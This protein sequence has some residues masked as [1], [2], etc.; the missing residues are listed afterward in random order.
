METEFCVLCGSALD[1]SG[2]CQNPSCRN[3]Q[4]A[5]KS[6]TQTSQESFA[7]S[8]KPL[9]FPEK[10]KKI[11]PDCI[12]ADLDEVH[13]KQYDIARLQTL[14]KGAR[15]EG[16]LQ[17]TN[18]RV[19]FRSTGFSIVGPT[20]LQHEFSIEEIA[21]IEIRKEAKLNVFTTA[22]LILA[23]YIIYSILNP[24]FSA[25][26][27]HAFIG[28]VFTL[29]LTAASVILFFMFQKQYLI[30]YAILCVILSALRLDVISAGNK[31]Q[32]LCA[33]AIMLF[34][35]VSMLY[36][37]FAPN[38]VVRILT[39][40]G[41]ASVDIRKKDSLFSFQHNEY[42]GFSQVMPGPDTDLAI[43]E[44]GAL[45]REVQQTGSYSHVE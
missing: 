43:Q 45:I 13:I 38:L 28:M 9:T 15:A 41:N 29:L 21:G 27:N 8:F 34:F 36:M 35:F 22:L 37:V 25:V 20:S 32:G 5:R 16:R 42:T 11:V 24:I 31:L 33:L 7:S 39:K 44:L 19:I 4:A 6:N 1:E 12:Q 26:Y 3:H 23:F 17:V 10:G 18:K 14:I 40:G 30:R 2:C